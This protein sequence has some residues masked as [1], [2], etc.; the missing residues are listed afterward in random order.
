MTTAARPTPAQM[1]RR[2]P[3]TVAAANRELTAPAPAQPHQPY[4]ALFEQGVLGTSMRPNPKF[5]AIALATHAD[6]SGQIPAGGQPRL[7]GLIHDTGLHVGQVVVA[8]NT[9]KQRGWIRQV[10]AAAPYDTA[11]LVLTIP[12]PIMARL[13]KAGRT[14]QGATTHA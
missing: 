14:P 13:M 3:A 9:L 12:R 6:A 10:Q 11:D 4:R 5:V 7:I 2:D 8:L 1:P